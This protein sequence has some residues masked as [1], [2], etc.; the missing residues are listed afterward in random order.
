[1]WSDS[2]QVKEPIVGVFPNNVQKRRSL[3]V[4]AVN[5][6]TISID[7]CDRVKSRKQVETK[8]DKSEF[9]TIM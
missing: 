1:M 2:S 3:T 8:S 5:N 7:K 6:I 9:P 4:C